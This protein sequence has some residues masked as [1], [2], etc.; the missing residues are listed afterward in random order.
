[1][2]IKTYVLV[3]AKLTSYCKQKQLC[4]YC[5]RCTRKKMGNFFACYIHTYNIWR[6]D[7]LYNRV[8][9]F[10]PVYADAIWDGWRNGYIVICA[11][12]YYYCALDI[13]LSIIYTKKSIRTKYRMLPRSD[14]YSLRCDSDIRA[15]TTIH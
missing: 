11:K 9:S 12:S 13:R 10:F 3:R 15:N 1:M 6:N 14:Q 4:K 2:L 8:C 5:R 7:Y